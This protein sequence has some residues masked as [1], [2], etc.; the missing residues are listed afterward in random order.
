MLAEGVRLP[1]DGDRRIEIAFADAPASDVTTPP[2]AAWMR[3]ALAR[4][5][6]L[7]GG[8]RDGRLVDRASVRAADADAVHVVDHVVRAA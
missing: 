8:E 3:A 4:L 6:G 7:A 5:E 1:H 2:R